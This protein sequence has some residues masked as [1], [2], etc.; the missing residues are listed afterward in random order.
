MLF[1]EM[2]MMSNGGSASSTVTRQRFGQTECNSAKWQEQLSSFSHQNQL[3]GP[4]VL[5][6]QDHGGIIRPERVAVH[7]AI[8][9]TQTIS[10]KVRVQFVYLLN[11][12]IEH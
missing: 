7:S 11:G 8:S 9:C 2:I 5:L 6:L 1:K 3:W 10:R 12:F 4:L